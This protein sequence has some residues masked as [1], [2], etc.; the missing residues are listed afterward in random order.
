M[1]ATITDEQFAAREL[2]RS[3]AAGSG[4]VAAARDVEHANQ[5]H[6]SYFAVSDPLVTAN[7]DTPEEYE[8]LRAGVPSEGNSV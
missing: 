3:W 6:I 7:V 8:K 2:V 4:A 1:S 5:E